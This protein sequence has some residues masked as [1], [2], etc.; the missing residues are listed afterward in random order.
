[1][2]PRPAA[3]R[4]AREQN[5][6]NKFCNPRPDFR[7]SVDNVAEF[8][9]DRLM[10]GFRTYQQRIEIVAFDFANLR[11]FGSKNLANFAHCKTVFA[12]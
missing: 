1:M 12:V 5:L 4:T 2:M 9:G 11:K 10:V 7:Y 8:L 6:Q 3:K